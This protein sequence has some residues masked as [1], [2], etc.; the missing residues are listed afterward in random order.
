ML[1]NNILGFF[2]EFFDKGTFA[3]SLNATFV[4]L[5]PKKQNAL[6]IQS[7]VSTKFWLKYWLIG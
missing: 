6:N 7:G 5:I 2:D 3:F 4:T 1:E